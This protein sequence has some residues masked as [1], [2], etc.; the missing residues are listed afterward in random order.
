MSLD[1]LYPLLA[2]GG[3]LVLFLWMDLKLFAR[4]REPS[5]REGAVWSIGWLVVGLLAGVV[6]WA[7]EGED[8][9]I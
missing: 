6:I 8:K 3:V 2:L 5:F 9:A 1:D 7:I 4:G